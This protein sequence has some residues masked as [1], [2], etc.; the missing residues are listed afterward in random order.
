D[1]GAATARRFPDKEAEQR[2]GAAQAISIEQVQ[3]FGVRIAGG[4]LHQPEAEEARIEIDIRLHIGGDA[5]D[6][7][8][9]AGH[10]GRLS[11][12]LALWCCGQ[13]VKRWPKPRPS[14][15]RSSL[16]DLPRDFHPALIRASTVSITLF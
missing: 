14:C 6:M 7:M 13:S 12:L 2:A 16:R 5:G 1:A 3:L 15:S 4:L 9:A 8:D 10:A 11:N